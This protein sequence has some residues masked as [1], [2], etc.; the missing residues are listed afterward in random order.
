MRQ[1]C[2]AGSVRR[3]TLVQN[4]PGYYDRK[5]DGDTNDG[6]SLIQ[7]TG[8][9]QIQVRSAARTVTTNQ[10]KDIESC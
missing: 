1:T 5:R 10:S 4:S 2:R 3:D 8:R 9:Q 6:R 7:V